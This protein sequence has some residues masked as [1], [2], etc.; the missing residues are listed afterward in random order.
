MKQAIILLTDPHSASQEALTRALNALAMAEECRRAGDEVALGFA[1][2]GTRWPKE[3]ARLDHPGNELYN[4]LRPHIVGASRACAARNGATA[5]VEAEGI[6]LLGDN[7]V[8][9]ELG[10][11]SIRRF[12]AEGWNVTV[13]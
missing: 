7:P 13:F 2:T 1:G 12:H 4:H 9:G 6:T 8:A 11:L 5:D 10:A 3:L